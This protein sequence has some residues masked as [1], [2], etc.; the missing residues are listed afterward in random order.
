MKTGLYTKLRIWSGFVLYIFVCLHLFNHSLGLISVEAMEIA[1]AYFITFWRH[2]VGTFLLYSSLLLHLALV[3]ISLAKRKSLKMPFSEA[4]QTIFALIFPFGLFLH[5]LGTR[6]AHLLFGFDDNYHN[7]LY[8]LWV[9]S[10]E[11]G[12]GNSILIILVWVHGTLGLYFWLRFKTWF[13]KTIS[14][15]FAL[16]IILP[17][18]CFLGFVNGGRQIESQYDAG[19]YIPPLITKQQTQFIVIYFYLGKYI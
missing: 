14:W 6:G 12:I 18:V 16:V 2:P 3:L 9:D 8:I 15:I 17:V 7:E 10:I 11:L 5:I 13:S 4:I 1:R 19:S